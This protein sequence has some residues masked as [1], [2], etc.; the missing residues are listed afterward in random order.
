MSLCGFIRALL[1]RTGNRLRGFAVSARD[2]FACC[3]VDSPPVGVTW[4]RPVGRS[5]RRNETITERLERAP[6][7]TRSRSNLCTSR[8]TE[9]DARTAN[10]LRMTGYFVL[11][12]PPTRRSP[13]PSRIGSH[14]EKIRRDPPAVETPGLNPSKCLIFASRRSVR[15]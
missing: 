13:F 1:R 15:K 3:S 2:P 10:R 11:F 5:V 14:S 12:L 6:L 8:R 9:P 4:F 7:I